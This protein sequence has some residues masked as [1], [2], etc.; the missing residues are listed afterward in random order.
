VRNFALAATAA[1]LGAT[2]QSP[3]L[4]EDGDLFAP[5][6]FTGVIDLRAAA[7]D[8]E[9]SWLDN[10]FG[11]ARFGGDGGDL[12]AHAKIAEASLVWRPRFTW[13]LDGYVHAQFTDDQGD[14]AIDLVEAFARY[15]SPPRDGL[16]LE[17][18][19]GIFYPPV[20]L[21]HDDEAW[22]TRYS[23]TPSAIN[24]WIGEEVKV[25]GVEAQVGRDVAGHELGLT[26]AAFGRNDLSGTLLSWR[27]WALH[28]VKAGWDTAWPLPQAALANL[29]VFAPWQAPTTEPS[30]ELDG[31]VSFYGRADWRAP[32]LVSVNVVHY[33]NAGNLGVGE[34]GQ[35]AWETRFTNLGVT[36]DLGPETLVLAQA[37]TGETLWGRFRPWRVDMGFATAYVLANRTVDDHSFT[38]RADWFATSDRTWIV[39]DDNNEEGWALTFAY[40]RE[41]GEHNRLMLE[42]LRVSSDR[43]ARAYGG[44]DPIEDQTLLQASWRITY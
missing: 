36:L 6:R 40:G 27:G 12:D 25:A 29:A 33:D 20:S 39:E 3:V 26:L 28:D 34:K 42:A 21:E 23:I 2:A 41:L 22:S 35:F 11:K 4:A 15:R 17:G 32:E 9:A 37:M 38:A 19:A 14:N 13:A 44:A 43:P 30:R 24:S 18:R 10:G 31:R 8:G 7:A 1:A 16:S 5:E